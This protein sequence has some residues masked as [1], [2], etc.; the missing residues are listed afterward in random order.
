M[1]DKDQHQ[2]GPHHCDERAALLHENHHQ[3]STPKHLDQDVPGY[4]PPQQRLRWGETE[5]LPHVNWGDLYF[6]LLIV[7]MAHNLAKILETDP[8]LSGL[9]YFTCLFYPMFSIWEE[10]MFYDSQYAPDDNFFHRGME[11]IHILLVGTIIQSIGSAHVM[12]HPS[13]YANT[14]IF[15]TAFLMDSL[16]AAG[17]HDDVYRN[18][19]GGEEAKYHAKDDLDRKLVA[20]TLYFSAVAFA[21]YEYFGVPSGTGQATS[22]P[23]VLIFVGI[24]FEQAA[25]SWQTIVLVPKRGDHPRFRVPLNMEFV[26]HRLGE[27]IMIVLGE[28]ILGLLLVQRSH[29]IKY[30]VVFYSGLLSVTFLQYLYY[31]TSPADVNDHA[32]KRSPRA[33]YTF[34]GILSVY[35]GSLIIVGG[36]YKLMLAQFL[37]EQIAQQTANAPSSC[38][39]AAA[40][41]VEGVVYTLAERRVRIANMFCWSLA[42]SQM[43]LD[44]MIGLHRG[45]RA[46]WALFYHRDGSI[47]GVRVFVALLNFFMIC[48]TAL[49]S[50]WTTRLDILSILGLVVIS[51]QVVTRSLK[52]RLFPVRKE[53]AAR[54]AMDAFPLGPDRD[55]RPWPNVTTPEI[56]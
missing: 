25:T 17:K 27:F 45:L 19:V 12:S 43:M 31:R 46:N 37:D 22:L 54:A 6:D 35:A 36:S 4:A 51:I 38:T 13:E 52:Q 49:L 14:F 3:N 33:G 56:A 44:F 39:T 30:F 42:F 32:L 1:T 7:A 20:L 34:M 5:V 55:H 15:S 28:S 53:S 40:A 2:D 16:C 18:V 8:S 23:V 26:P 50:Q 29:G 11:I 9:F 47:N 24:V 48:I 10:R 41:A 21:A